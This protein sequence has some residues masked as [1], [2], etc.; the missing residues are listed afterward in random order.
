MPMNE[1]LQAIRTRI[2]ALDQQI[3]DL[4]NE[5]ASLAQE[6]AEVKRAEGGDPTFYRPEREAQVLTAVMQRNRGPISN[7]EMA[8]LFREIMSACLALEQPMRI[9]FL[10]P[11]GTFTQ[12]AALKH[13]GH[14]VTTVPLATIDEVFREVEA[15][16][17]D[18]GV[19]PVENSTEGVV[20]HT[21]D[22]MMNSPLKISGEV[23]I[24]I[25]QH[26]MGRVSGMGDIRRIYSH[27]QSLAQCRKWLDTHLPDV[28]R[29]DVASNAEAARLAAAEEQAAAIGPEAAAALYGLILLASKIEDQPDNTTR[30]LVLGRAQAAPSGNDKTSLLV[31]SRNK[32]GMLF[33]LL[34]PLARND[35]S[36]TRI[37]SRPS[38]QAMWEY[39][40]FVDVEGHMNDPQVAA[41]LNELEQHALLFKV[42]GSFPKGVL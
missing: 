39:V 33:K 17:A 30:F 11:E 37:E 3:Q 29:V 14:S 13:F 32:P 22:R 18:Y 31:A 1:R 8:R 9:A 10:G 35:V 40:F 19:V 7:E 2:D 38:R 6:V 5:R 25:H 15:G 27:R 23:A 12:A 42:L 24:R 41:A 34:E 16:G 21:L 28:E 36:M 20:T 26:L 4:I